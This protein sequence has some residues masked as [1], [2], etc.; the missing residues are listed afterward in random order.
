MSL[1]GKTIWSRENGSADA[2][3]ISR[4]KRRKEEEDEF[5]SSQE[6]GLDLNGNDRLTNGGG[7]G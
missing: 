6:G 3:K 5:S 1:I 4:F 2:V 7:F